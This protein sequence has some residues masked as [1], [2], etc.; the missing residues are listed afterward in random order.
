ML[1]LEGVARA[2]GARREG[3]PDR[4]DGA[5]DRLDGADLSRL[6]RAV[7]GRPASDRLVEG[8]T[9]ADGAAPMAPSVRLTDEGRARDA[10]DRTSLPALSA[11][12][13]VTLLGVAR[14]ARLPAAGLVDARAA[15]ADALPDVVVWGA[16]R[17]AEAAL[18]AARRAAVAAPWVAVTP[19]PSADRRAEATRGD[20]LYPSPG[21]VIGE[22]ACV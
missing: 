9:R 18:D 8:V 19:G 14:T 11:S 15:G 21:R 4:V 22:R 13:G 17:A 2:E 5:A 10:L 7:A 3:V 12:E 20:S 6:D 16:T 1:P